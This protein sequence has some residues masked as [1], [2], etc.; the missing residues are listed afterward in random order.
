MLY[1]MR[2]VGESIIINGNIEV[3]LIEVKGK[4]A[5][6]GFE[7]PEDVTVLRKEVHDRI[8]EENLAASKPSDATM[9]DD[10]AAFSQINVGQ[11]RRRGDVL[12]NGDI[13]QGKAPSDN[14]PHRR[15]QDSQ[16]PTPKDTP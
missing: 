9:L 4:G 1:L 13:V 14:H 8:A 10:L 2:K 3:K 7:F 6:L 15:K 11:L 5:K 16:K 12:P